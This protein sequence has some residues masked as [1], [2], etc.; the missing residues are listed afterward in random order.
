VKSVISAL[1]PVERYP[2]EIKGLFSNISNYA[3]DFVQAAEIL[4]KQPNSTRGEQK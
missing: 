2:G 1:Q 4:A 3:P